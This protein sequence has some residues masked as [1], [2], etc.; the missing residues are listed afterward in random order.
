M[1]TGS[2]RTLAVG[3]EIP[4]SEG[5][6]REVETENPPQT[7]AASG[8]GARQLGCEVATWGNAH[9]SAAV[10]VARGQSVSLPTINRHLSDSGD[11]SQPVT[12]VQRSLI[13]VDRSG[14]EKGGFY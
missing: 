8:R 5:G 1:V 7:Q 4:R 13:A 2:T 11:S 12:L 10:G 14:S 3:F 9:P 6:K